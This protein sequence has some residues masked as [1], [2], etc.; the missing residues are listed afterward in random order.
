LDLIAIFLTAGLTILGGIIVFVSGQVITR[1]YLDPVDNLLQV[2]GEVSY[3]LVYYAK[4]YTNPGYS[5]EE[6]AKEIEI[7][8]RKLASQLSAKANAVKGY[9][10]FVKCKYLPSY[11]NVSIAKQELIGLSNSVRR[12]DPT[13]N[14][15][16]EK[17]IQECLNIVLD[18]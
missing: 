12:G 6:V 11:T 18:D 5:Q 2:I 3:G 9:K 14:Y 15:G 1:F 10:F 17:R 4:Y 7:E 16:R 8:L 13:V